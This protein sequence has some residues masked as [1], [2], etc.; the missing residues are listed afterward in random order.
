MPQVILYGLNLILLQQWHYGAD[1]GP[2]TGLMPSYS[3]LCL[4]W[5][6]GPCPV[7]LS[8]TGHCLGRNSKPAQWSPFV[9]LFLVIMRFKLQDQ[10]NNKRGNKGGGSSHFSHLLFSIIVDTMRK[11]IRRAKCNTVAPTVKKQRHTLP[12][13]NVFL[14]LLQVCFCRYR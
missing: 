3:P 11:C 10:N 4:S 8:H 6:T 5:T 7:S 13:M 14:P 9:N 12:T 2:A 1:S